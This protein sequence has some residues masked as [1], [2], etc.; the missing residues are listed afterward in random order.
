MKL[1]KQQLG[2]FQ[3][4]YKARGFVKIQDY[5]SSDELAK[6]R[7]IIGDFHQKW[8][9]DNEDFFQTRAINSAYITSPLYLDKTQKSSL[10]E[11]IASPKIT[12]FTEC[13]IGE[14]AKFLNT[15]IFFDPQ[16][17]EQ[18]NYWHRDAQYHTPID[19]QQSLLQQDPVLHFR[20]PLFDERGMELVPKSHVQWDTP[21][22]LDIR[23]ERNGRKCHEDIEQG[24]EV[25]LRAGDLLIFSANMIHR[26]LYGNDRLTFDILYCASDPSVLAYRRNNCLPDSSMPK[27]IQNHPLFT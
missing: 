15:Q 6:L 12:N 24:V 23:L 7:Q 9:A 27:H 21:E 11:F 5:F 26:G 13:L 4:E 22:Q 8:C 14:D 19:Q 16:Q 20:V 10:F 25:P 1:T 3:A 18:Q 2:Q 17:P